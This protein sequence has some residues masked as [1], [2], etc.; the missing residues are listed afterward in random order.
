[1]DLSGFNWFEVLAAALSAF[2][3]GG[4]WYG[5]LFGKKWQQL[6]GLTD[7][8]IAQA[9]MGLIYGLAFLLNVFLATMLS[10]FIEI[11]MMMGSGALAGAAMGAV[12]GVIFIVP[13]F[14]VNYLF[15][16]RPLALY[17]IDVGYQI[18]QMALMGAI[19]GAWI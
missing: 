3:L 13:T 15:S 19:M 10:L 12:L 7:E 16:R 4:L 17:A 6:N 1:M 5:P 9:N 11:A 18:L 8:R 2:V 14:G